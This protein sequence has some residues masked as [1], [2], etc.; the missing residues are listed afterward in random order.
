[1]FVVGLSQ[2]LADADILKRQEY[3]GKF[4]RI[5]KVVVNQSTSYVGSQ[6]GGGGAGEGVR[7]SWE[8]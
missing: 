7:K 4:G 2:R 6:V 1:M 3:F 5:H 8:E